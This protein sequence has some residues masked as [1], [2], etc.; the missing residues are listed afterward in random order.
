MEH[1]DNLK[2]TTSKNLKDFIEHTGRSHQWIISKS[3]IPKSTYYKM[4]NGEG[5]LDKHIVK[6]IDLFGIDNP[7]YFHN[8]NFKIEARQDPDITKHI[9]ANYVQV[10]GEKEA[11][12]ETLT[13][14]NDFVNMIDT[15]K[16]NNSTNNIKYMRLFE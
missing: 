7:Y 5:D 16:R 2:L 1:I 11:F 12:I 13:M 6:I 10:E 9:A 8:V 14:M 3:G 4:L 15:L